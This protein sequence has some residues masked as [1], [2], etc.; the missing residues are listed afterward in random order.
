MRSYNRILSAIACIALAVTSTQSASAEPKPTVVKSESK[1][2]QPA[3]NLQVHN[4]NEVELDLLIQALEATPA[5]LQEADPKT[6]P[7]YRNQLAYSLDEFSYNRKIAQGEAFRT[8]WWLCS[9]KVATVIV[10]YG[11]P[12]A[13]VVG[14]LK[15]ARKLWGGIKGITTAL[16][17]GAAEAE[18]GEEA[19][20][21]IEMLLGFNEVIDACFS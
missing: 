10:Q 20:Q 11:I 3:G 19:V 16:E 2:S 14:W 18:I 13:K 7:D 15:N 8:T 9:L 6:T 21:V 4:E 17:T 1:Y 5:T 12:V